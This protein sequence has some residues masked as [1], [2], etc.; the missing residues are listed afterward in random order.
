MPEIGEVARVV[1]FLRKHLVNRTIASVR[2]QD[3]EIVYGKVGTTASAVAA[4]LKGKSV[5]SA[6]QQG[7]YFWLTMSSPPHLLM[8]LGMTGWVK[9]SNEETFYYKRGKEDKNAKEDEAPEWPPKY[10]K[11]ILTMKGQ[12]ECEAAF[13]DGRRLARIRLIDVPAEDLRT[14][15]P[16]KENG[17]DPYIDKAVLTPDWLVEKLRKKKVPVKAWLLDQANISGVGN[18]VCDEVLYNAKIHPEERSNTLTDGQF[19]QLHESLMY[20]CD[21]ACST[22]SDSSQF[23]VGSS[24]E[25]GL[26][27]QD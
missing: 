9:F 12:P 17:P 23:P 3:D 19:K 5:L 21:L 16:L 6:G 24:D 26:P 15:S 20:V 8:H 10:W 13:V 4:A 25:G 2:V 7:K 27:P 14:T 1:H 22:L 18:W 11:F